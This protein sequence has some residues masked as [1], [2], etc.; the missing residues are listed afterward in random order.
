MSSKRAIE[1]IYLRPDNIIYQ[2]LGPKISL[3]ILDENLERL[4]E[5]EAKLKAKGLP[6]LMLVNASRL[7]VGIDTA[8]RQRAIEV[9]DAID[10]ERVGMFGPN[11]YVRFI[12]NFILRTMH[13]G[14][15]IHIFDSPA[16]AL[17]WLMETPELAK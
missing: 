12:A 11:L 10:Y 6:V 13:R 4:K 8:T 2:D 9:M 14:E 17:A 3:A 15:R 7:G 16:D 1:D 5:L